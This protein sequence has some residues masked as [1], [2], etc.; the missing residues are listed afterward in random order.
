MNI[1]M[2]NRTQS[3]SPFVDDHE[4][5][6]SKC[7]NRESI[8]RRNVVASLDSVAMLCTQILD[9]KQGSLASSLQDRSQ[10]RTTQQEKITN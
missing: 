5:V 10:L 6:L 1:C 7:R 3:A 9:Q 4:L 8:T 2:S